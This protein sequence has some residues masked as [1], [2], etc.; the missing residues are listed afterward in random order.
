LPH[1]LNGLRRE[2]AT[3]RVRIWLSLHFVVDASD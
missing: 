2:G 3:L 1:G